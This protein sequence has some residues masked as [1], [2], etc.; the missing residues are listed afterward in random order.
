MRMCAVVRYCCRFFFFKQNTAYEMRISDWSSDVCSS[1][2]ITTEGTRRLVDDISG[3]AAPTFAWDVVRD[4]DERQVGDIRLRFVSTDHPVETMAVRV[5][6]TSGSLA[7][8][9]DTGARLDGRSLDP[10]GTGVDLLVVE[11][12]LPPGQEGLVQHLTAPP[13]ARAEIGRA[14]T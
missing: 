13:A 1:D 7:Y 2:L 4:G 10:D 5:D 14:P 12:S 6:G 9:A 8:T 3:G 11:A